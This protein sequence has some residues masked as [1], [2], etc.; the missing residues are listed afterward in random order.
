MV[1]SGTK[2]GETERGRERQRDDDGRKKSVKSE[3]RKVDNSTVVKCLTSFLL[4]FG[5]NPCLHE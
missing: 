1:R 3:R 2:Y 4:N 5:L